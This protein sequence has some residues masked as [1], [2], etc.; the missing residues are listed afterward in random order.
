MNSKDKSKIDRWILAVG[1]I[2]VFVV[3]LLAA[4]FVSIEFSGIVIAFFIGLAG[5][6][7]DWIKSI[8]YQPSLKTVYMSGIPFGHKVGSRYPNG[9]FECF[10]Y[11][12]RIKVENTGN[13]GMK[14]VE[15]VA[16]ECYREVSHGKY[17]RVKD[18]L[19]LNLSWAH[20]E[21]NRLMPFIRDDFYWFCSF[22]YIRKSADARLRAFD[23]FPSGTPFEVVCI[24][25]TIPQPNSGEHILVPCD[26]KIVLVIMGKNLKPEKRLVRLHLEDG[27]DDNRDVMFHRNMLSINELADSGPLP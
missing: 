27:W 18:F 7:Q 6:F 19:P 8:L 23:K 15:I 2:A 24:L 22:G 13:T 26:Y 10:N 21:K 4:L 14:D 17:E 25:D 1:I 9:E 20:R 12:F 16:E 5:I 3:A 11:Y